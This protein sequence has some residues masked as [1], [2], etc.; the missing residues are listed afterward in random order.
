ML[1][2]GFQKRQPSVWQIGDVGRPDAEDEQ[3]HVPRRLGLMGL[4]L[5][6][7]LLVI[8]IFEVRFDIRQT[9][10]GF[11]NAPDGLPILVGESLIGVSASVFEQQPFGELA[12]PVC[13][14]Q[15][16]GILREFV[17]PVPSL[18]RLPI[19]CVE[20]EQGGT[21][22]LAIRVLLAIGACARRGDDAT[23]TNA[24]VHIVMRVRPHHLACH[25][26]GATCETCWTMPAS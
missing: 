2:G 15:R 11:E 22:M 24:D 8:E 18:L 1:V 9:A 21:H 23:M 20:R 26:L 4:C 16:R 13:A 7:E 25:R 14:C 10:C 12:V 6:A 17:I 3:A 19:P 5:A